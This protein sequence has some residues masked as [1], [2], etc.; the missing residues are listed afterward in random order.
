MS[1]TASNGIRP[2]FEP[3]K[4]QVGPFITTIPA[5]A[6]RPGRNGS[7]TYEGVIDGV[8]LEAQ[9]QPTGTLR[10]TFD[11]EAKGANLSGATSPVQVSSGI[12]D[13]AGLTSVNAHF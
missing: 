2:A 6:F 9:I 7:Y 1:S 13:D 5:G 3:V 4:L 11:A 10:Y 8:W 12:G